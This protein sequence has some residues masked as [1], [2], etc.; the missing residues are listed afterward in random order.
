MRHLS[1]CIVVVFLVLAP[2]G[3]AAT[4][5]PARAPIGAHAVVAGTELDDP[6]LAVTY[7]SSTGGRIVAPVETRSATLIEFIVPDGAVSGEARLVRGTTT[8]EAFAFTV[9]P[10]TGI[11][12]SATLAAASQ[13]HDVLKQ[14]TGPFV[15]LPGGISYV[16]D[17]G[18]HQICA[19][20]PNGE[21]QVIAGTGTPG[22]LDGAAAVARF[23]DPR[24]I[25]IDGARGRTYIADSGNHVIRLLS[26]NGVVSTFAGSGQ[27][28]DRDGG[29]TQAGFKEPSALAIDMDGNLYVADT[30]NDKVRRITLDGVVTT[31]A[32][33]NRD[34][35]ANGAALSALFNKPQGIAVRDSAVFVADTNNHVLRKIENG[36]VSTFAGTG[37]PGSVDGAASN[38]DFKQPVGL[39]F[40]SAGELIVADSGNH[41]IRRVAAGVVTTIAG[42][43]TP[44]FV[45]G[46]ILSTVQYKQPF[47]VAVEGAIFI[48]DTMNDAIRILYPAVALTDIYPRRGDPNG[49]EVVH[50]FGDGFVP[51]QTQVTWGGVSV[52]P[53][54]ASSTEL[55]IETPSGALGTAD[56]V[57]TTPAG[58]AHLDDVFEYVPPFVALRI[59]PMS[60]TLDP[61]QSRQL[62][63]SGLTSSGSSTD[64]TALVTWTSSNTDIATVDATGLLT[65]HAIGSATVTATYG[66]LTG[67]ATITVRD[68]HPPDPIPPDPSTVAPP[69]EPGAS[70]S[71]SDAVSFLYTG[72]NAIQQGVFP[73]T[74]DELRAGVVRGRVLDSSGNPL[75]AV[76]VTVA[77][78]PELGQ[79]LSRLDGRFDLVVNAGGDLTLRYVRSG[80]ISAERQVRTTWRDYVNAPDVVLV[81]LDANVNTISAN[82]ATPQ[83]TRGS[84]VT[85]DDGTRR[86]TLIFPAGTNASMVLADGS[87][88][89]LAAMSV[90]ATEYTVGA[91]GPLTMPAA[92]PPQSG[93]TYCVELSIDEALAANAK[94]VQFSKPVPFYVENFLGFNTGVAV[95]HAFYDRERHTW[96]PSPNGKVIRIVAIESGAARV[97][98]NGDGVADDIG[99]DLAERQQLATL[100]AAGTSLWRVAITH[101]TPVDLNYSVALKAPNDAISFKGKPKT[102][103]PQS[104]PATTLGSI[105]ECENQTL[106]EVLPVTG[107][108]FGLHY[109]SD[110]MRGRVASRTLDIPVIG[111]TVP[112][113]LLRMDIEVTVAGQTT[114][115]TFSPAPNQSFRYVWNGLDAYGR[116]VP[117]G[118]PVTVRTTYVYEGVYEFPASGSSTFALPSGLR[119]GVDSRVPVVTT[120][121]WQATLGS[122]TADALRLGGWTLTPHHFY[123][124]TTRTLYRGDGSRRSDVPQKVG[125]PNGVLKTVAGRSGQSDPQW[126]GTGGPARDAAIDEVN[127]TAFTPDGTLY[128][129][130]FGFIKKITPQGQLVH[131]AGK[132]PIVIKPPIPTAPVLAATAQLYGARGIAFGPDGSIYFVEDR[133]HIVRRITPDGMLVR[134]AGT[135][136]GAPGP[137][138]VPAISSPLT[139]PTDVAVASD[140]SVYIAESDAFRVR[141]V[142]PDGL[143]YTVAGTGAS[144][145]S[146]DGGPATAAG[147]REISCIAVGPDGSLY[148]GE[149]HRIRRVGPDGIV[150]TIAGNGIKGSTGDGG[151]ATAAQ[152]DVSLTDSSFLTV[153][154]GGNICFAETAKIRCIDPA[155]TINTFA[156]TGGQIS[157][158]DGTLATA[159]DIAQLTTLTSA[160]DGGLW[161]QERF[162]FL[163]RR[164]APNLP[165]FQGSASE[166]IVADGSVVHVFASDGR[167]LRTVDAETGAELVHFNYANGLLASIVDHDGNTATIE[168]NASG[169]AIAIVAP[170][171]QRTTLIGGPRLEQLTTAPGETTFFDYASDGLMKTMTD[172]RGRQTKFEWNELG[173]LRRDEDPE[174]GAK[175]LSRTEMTDGH[176]VTITTEMGRST[177]YTT[178]QFESADTSRSMVDP[179]NLQATAATTKKGITTSTSPDGMTMTSVEASDPVFGMQSPFTKSATLRWPSGRTLTISAQRQATLATSNDPLSVTTR[180]DEMT[181]NSKMTRLVFSR[182]TLSETLTTPE[183][184]VFRQFFDAAGRVRRREAPGILPVEITYDGQG[185]LGTIAQSTH[186]QTF[187][188]NVK[189]ELTS[190]RDAFGR[191]MQFEYDGAGRVTRQ[192]LPDLREISFGYDAAGNLTSVTPSGR[193]AHTFRY[194]GVNLASAYIPPLIAGAGGTEYIYNVDRDL[195]RILRPDGTAIEFSYDD[196][197]RLLALTAADASRGYHY[198][199]G[200]NL[201]SITGA[202]VSLSYL[203]DGSTPTEMAWSGPVS[204]R[205]TW[206]YNA[207]ALLASESVVGNTITFTY[208]NDR[209]LKTAGALRLQ[210]DVNGILSSTQLGTSTET[211]V[212]DPHGDLD[213]LTHQDVDP[214]TGMPRTL[215]TTDYTRDDGGRIVGITENVGGTEIPIGYH[216]DSA[217]RLDEVT[218]PEAIVR[219]IYDSNGNRTAREVVTSTSTA[220]ETAT[221]DA[222]D[223]LLNYEGTQYTY[224]A[225]G[226]LLTKT[227]VAG[228]TYYTY[229]SLGNLLKVVLPD[230]AVI[231]YII[232][233]QN[234]RVG[235]KLNGVTTQRWLYADQLRI[236]AEL[237]AS[238]A[239]TKRFVYGAR[240]NVPDYMIYGGVTYR[241]YSDHLGSPHAVVNL[242]TG[243]FEETLRFD[244]FGYALIDTHP[245]LIP[246]G[247]AGGLYDAATGLVRFGTRDYDGRVGRWMSKEPLGFAGGFNFYEYAGN[248]AINFADTNGLEVKPADFI[249]PLRPGD[250]RAFQADLNDPAL[251]DLVDFP[252]LAQASQY[253]FPAGTPAK[254]R[255]ECVSLTKRFAGVPC[256][257]GCWRQGPAILGS[258]FPPGTAIAAGWMN[259]R[260]PAGDV[261]KNSGIYVRTNMD[262]SIEMIDQWPGHMAMTR[263]V[264]PRSVNGSSNDS[265]AYHVI[266]VPPGT[267]DSNL[268]NCSCGK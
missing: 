258:N 232:D 9:I 71:F 69:F 250:T 215:F 217:G 185:R 110:R 262:G 48:A 210:R 49:G 11:V 172:P 202:N 226:D 256:A 191:T 243:I 150:T 251:R 220:V 121:V 98:T 97:D 64:L 218:Y 221:Y 237:D 144:V 253:Y 35:F 67:T 2:W 16:A 77:D 72:P 42:S 130:A 3:L 152:I 180:T 7:P 33:A 193:P 265:R 170:G 140:G 178:E 87:T 63:A 230:G 225:G 115:Q 183:G 236:V 8:L 141:R 119:T 249:G 195:E 65:A 138:D 86:A 223:R 131:V 41:Q 122:W 10:Q 219:Y 177:S 59:D 242:T 190:V 229:D 189:N 56:I 32:G 104:C 187:E 75:P 129:S 142:S 30:G 93:Y 94:T 213:G 264:F 208:D 145:Y 259:G 139:F 70:P 267:S 13:S 81:A 241:I 245:S 83:I 228:T 111:T 12:K 134:F 182:T 211:F 109:Q 57:V 4:F 91:N 148:V 61:G 238:G 15:A 107:T 90:R 123:D 54:Y 136:G 257:Y 53:T 46:T 164:I 118:V 52:E 38:A 147:F 85:D 194:N 169:D 25:V 248:D 45:D 20:L 50:I 44:G 201:D 21:V 108:S 166:I 233:G 260:Y 235:R 27:P 222:Q 73:G 216:Y 24:A 255:Q 160:P 197:G 212:F 137:N 181:T 159:A 244:E 266:T 146:G 5:I 252:D 173:M 227:D 209:M 133:Q 6:A 184:H 165:D 149:R 207:D 135:G 92:L 36:I 254:Y 214:T 174:G 99:I 126:L 239:V 117:T 106:G 113:S 80:F 124:V 88:Q 100:Y 157:Q 205:I 84:S 1:I 103:T 200:G 206:S 101:F 96:V 186:H 162:S 163:M 39:G 268:A 247:F 17:S 155:G 175:T 143:I 79:T 37:H 76:H 158:Q 125:T 114:K 29:S 74:I 14:P 120:Q 246:F 151:P 128:L 68:P 161:F 82:A 196:G 199:S 156:G 234:R 224:T 153:T 31:L 28:E 18:H 34:G 26:A 78:H 22:Y 102:Y 47:G 240:T 198:N 231:E 204:G 176:R 112:A 188:Y 19:V 167:H 154:P 171:G 62:N 60:V 23:R 66:S 168:R 192:I 105:I 263:T 203:Y 116:L 40:N 89:S 55:Q 43:G 127:G 51:G 95:P 58:S 132:W 261:D 179:S